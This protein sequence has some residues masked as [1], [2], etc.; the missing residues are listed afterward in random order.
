MQSP[1]RYEME[2]EY[3]EAHP[4]EL[5]ENGEGGFVP[6]DPRI[7]FDLNMIQLGEVLGVPAPLVQK[8]PLHWSAAGLILLDAR[9]IMAE[10]AQ[11]K[12]K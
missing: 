4:E 1:K 5:D 3:Q 10:K 12:K 8:M 6:V 11:R 7:D 9:A 2:L